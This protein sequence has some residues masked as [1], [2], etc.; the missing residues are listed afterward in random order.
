MSFQKAPSGT[1]GSRFSMPGGVARFLSRMLIKQHRR[2]GNKFQGMDI[3]YLTTTGAKSGAERQ[4]PLSYFVDSDDGWLVVASSGGA[5]R[6]PGWYHNIAAHPDRIWA[7]VGGQRMRVSAEQLD[8]AAREQAWN[9]IVAAQPRYAAY[10]QKT[11]RALPVIRLARA[12]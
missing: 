4:A 8:G 7:E 11:D 2:G 10:Q 3:L 1:R 9:R 6:H 5:A 12:T